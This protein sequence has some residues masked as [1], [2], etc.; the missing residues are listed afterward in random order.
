LSTFILESLDLE[1]QKPPSILE[2]LPSLKTSLGEERA[3]GRGRR[4]LQQNP[5]KVCKI[6]GEP[7]IRA[8][9]LI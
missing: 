4:F 1:D 6:K 8:R 7:L 5:A 2:A 9:L 3:R